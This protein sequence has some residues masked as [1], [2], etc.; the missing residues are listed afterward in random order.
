MIEVTQARCILRPYRT[1]DIPAL[2]RYANNPLIF[3]NVRDGF[4]NPYTRE[5]AVEWMKL[6]KEKKQDGAL[7]L[8]IE[9]DN[10]LIGSIGIH[11]NKDVY[12]LTAEIGYW[13]AEPFWNQG[14]MS[15]CVKILT[16]YA[17]KH[18]DLI[19]IYAGV[20][21]NNSASMRVLE[22]AGYHLE[23]IHKK[24][25]IKLGKILD[26]HVYVIFKLES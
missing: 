3:A 18:S 22:K 14:I 2:V 1:G 20:F 11:P 9:Q 6:A 5:K 19:K 23:A 26:E 15:H 13:L 25:V 21:S 16:E 12:R 7:I 8:A 24:A 17:F 10:E 4:P